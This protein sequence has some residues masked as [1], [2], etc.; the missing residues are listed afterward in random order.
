MSELL[1]Y[2]LVANIL[3]VACWLEWLIER[4]SASTEGKGER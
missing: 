3:F 1:E 4:V 2:F